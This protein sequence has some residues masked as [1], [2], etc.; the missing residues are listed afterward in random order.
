M[1][2]I[3][4]G[5]LFL[6][7]QP[8]LGRDSRIKKTAIAVF[9][10]KQFHQIRATSLVPALKQS[11]VN[12]NPSSARAA[13]HLHDLQQGLSPKFYQRVKPQLKLESPS[14]LKTA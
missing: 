1:N 6:F 7:S 12:S 10:H 13:L 3:N 4:S 2:Y 9:S 8:I 11:Q 5:E 14:R